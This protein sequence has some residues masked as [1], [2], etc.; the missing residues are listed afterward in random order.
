MVCLPPSLK[1]KL[2]GVL[3]NG[4][5]FML[6]FF[7]KWDKD[8]CFLTVTGVLSGSVVDLPILSIS[9]PCLSATLLFLKRRS[10]LPKFSF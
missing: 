2:G 10:N 4:S 5:N 9:I 1:S 6:L 8:L 7:N 3:F